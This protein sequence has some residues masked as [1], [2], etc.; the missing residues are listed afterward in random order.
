MKDY[1]TS[2]FTRLF[3]RLKNE[4]YPPPVIEENEPGAAPKKTKPKKVEQTHFDFPS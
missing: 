4:K 3:S 2:L 1:I